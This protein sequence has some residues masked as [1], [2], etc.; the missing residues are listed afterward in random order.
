[1][2]KEL[3]GK[4]VRKMGGTVE[5]VVGRFMAPDPASFEAIDWKK[6]KEHFAQNQENRTEP[7]WKNL[8]RWMRPDLVKCLLPSLQQFELGD[9]GGPA[10]LIAFNAERF[11]ACAPE[12]REVVDAWFA[13]EKEHARLLGCAVE[14]FG[15]SHIDSHWSFSA[16]CGVRRLCGVRFELQVLL[17][18]EIVSAAYYRVLKRHANDQPIKDMC[19]LINRD[20]AGHIAF[21]LDRL[22][23]A[24]RSILGLSRKVW[25]AQF[26]MN[27]YAAATVLWISHG[28]CLIPLGA[29]TEEYFQEVRAGISNFTAQLKRRA[30]S[31]R[32][33]LVPKLN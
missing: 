22:A 28:P 15:G 7:D 1:M 8:N 6:W 32:A 9:G 10:Q 21:H 31:V 33:G 23:A 12:I 20:E 24:D 4:V 17:L 30:G 25:A 19:T 5:N 2:M 18:T 11:R 16:F 27:G 13:E 14:R 26:W 29:T 3:V